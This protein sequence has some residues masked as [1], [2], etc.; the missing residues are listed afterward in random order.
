MQS[1]L[2]LAFNTIGCITFDP[3][4]VLAIRKFEHPVLIA[5]TGNIG[6]KQSHCLNVFNNIL[7][8]KQTCLHINTDIYT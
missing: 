8:I 1:I 4:L 2:E 7:Q 6:E 5:E 3:A